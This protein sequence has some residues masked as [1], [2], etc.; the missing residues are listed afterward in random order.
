MRLGKETLSVEAMLLAEA[1]WDQ[2]FHIQPKDL[3]PLISEKP[4][5]LGVDEDNLAILIYYN[6]CVRC[7]VQQKLKP[8]FF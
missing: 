1:L 8:T 6:H 4:L 5:S 7:R 3:L 2:D